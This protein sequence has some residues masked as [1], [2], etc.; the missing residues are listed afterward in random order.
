[1]ALAALGITIPQAAEMSG[2]SPD[3]IHQIEA[4]Q[5]DQASTDKL[6]RALES[7]GVEFISENDGVGVMFRG[8]P[9]GDADAAIPVEN[10]TSENDE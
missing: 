3:A 10:L 2:V 4:G 5:Q 8:K 6:R 7:V 1:M 9:L